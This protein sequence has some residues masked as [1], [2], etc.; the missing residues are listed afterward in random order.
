MIWIFISISLVIV[1]LIY[2]LYSILKEQDIKE[3][4]I[5]DKDIESIKKSI[6][7]SKVDPQNFIIGVNDLKIQNQDFINLKNELHKKIIWMEEFLNLVLVNIV[8]GGNIL[9]EWVPG[10]AKTKTIQVLS[11]ILEMDF[12]RIQFTPDMLP[13]DI[14][15]TEIFNAKT[16]DFE[17]KIWP[18]FTNILLA[19]EINRTTPKVQSALL[20]AMQE[21]K[22]SIWWNTYDI[23]KPFFVL[24]TQNPLEQEWTYPLPEAQVDRFLFKIIISYPTAKEEKLVL[25]TLEKEN[26]I[27]LNKVLDIRKILEIQ[28]NLNNVKISEDIKDYIVRLVE[29]TRKPDSRIMYGASPRAA[30]GLMFAAKA[31]AFL[32][33]RDY[34]EH[35]DVQRLCLSVLRHRILLSYDAKVDGLNED[36]VLLDIL[37]NITLE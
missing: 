34:V 16:R 5:A 13:S 11:E 31:L 6:K 35:Y 22:V 36:D 27:K 23:P 24:A 17:V 26:N 18:V 10:L 14:I 12:K 30:I 32:Q 8:C 29:S 28:N 3:I 20:E 21:K 7:H 37:P 15:W 4:K 19:D 33:D 9:V 1:I 25:D 2:I